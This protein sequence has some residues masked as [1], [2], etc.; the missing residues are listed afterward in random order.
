[1][2]QVVLPTAIVCNFIW[3]M[4]A[5]A[6][7]EPELLAIRDAIAQGE[8]VTDAPI[9][10]FQN[11]LGTVHVLPCRMTAFD[12]VSMLILEHKGA[13]IPMFFPQVQVEPGFDDLGNITW[14]DT[15]VTGISS[16]ALVTSIETNEDSVHVRT[17]SRIPPG[18]GSGHLSTSYGL[19]PDGPRLDHSSVELDGPEYYGFWPPKTRSA[20]P[21]LT[22][23]HDLVGF[24][25][26]ETPDFRAATPL[27]VIDM[28]ET[29]FPTDGLEGGR[30]RLDIT[31]S[32]EGAS[33]AANLI[34]TGWADDSV[35]GQVFRVLIARDGGE[36]RL[37]GLGHA[38]VCW[39]GERR[40]TTDLCP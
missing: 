15:T 37:T 22:L 13:L 30:P 17:G 20:T 12:E 39:R 29:G 19:T 34:E 9:R 32:E 18:L 5:H 33:I 26:Q 27:A 38:W 6:A 31:M 23:A 21:E 25:E 2:K 14:A 8:C 11:E 36:W 28:I 24:N 10:S 40:V 16:S 3:S 4:G 35:S 1:M 7:T